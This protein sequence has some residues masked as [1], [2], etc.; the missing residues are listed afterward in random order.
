MQAGAGKYEMK[1]LP[2]NGRRKNGRYVAGL[3]YK[4]KR[5]A[6]ITKWSLQQAEGIKNKPR[7]SWEVED[8]FSL[9]E[10]PDPNPVP[11]LSL[12]WINLYCRLSLGRSFELTV[13]AP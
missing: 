8:K 10:Y 5:N 1:L 13:F 2:N 3:K 4:S 6:V 12:E 7:L 9:G 11:F